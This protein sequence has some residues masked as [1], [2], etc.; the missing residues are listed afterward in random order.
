MPAW[1]DLDAFLELDDFAVEAVIQPA[2]GP[3]RT[4]T[5]LF[6][7][8]VASAHLG[9]Y[10]RDQVRPTFMGK[11]SDFVG[12]HARD[13]LTLAGVTYDVLKEPKGDGNGMATLEL[14]SQPT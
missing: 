6:D 9:D 5:G 11:L 13:T 7:D 14:R 8:P 1:D 10:E 3:S 4:V 12:I 2:S